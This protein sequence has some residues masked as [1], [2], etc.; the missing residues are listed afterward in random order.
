MNRKAYLLTIALLCTVAQGAWAEAVNYIYYT[1]NDDG[2]TVTKHTGSQANYNTINH[3]TRK[4][5]AGVLEIWWVVSSNVTIDTKERLDCY[6]KVNIILKDGCTLTVPKGIR[7]STDCT[8]NI[9]AQSEDEATMGGIHAEGGGEDWAAIGG[10]KDYVGGTLV[11]H[12]GNIY[13]EAKNNNAAGIGGGNGEKS[14]MMSITIYGGIV[15]AKGKN[16]GAGIGAGKRNNTVGTINIYGGTITAE[17]GDYGAGIGGA[18]DRGGWHTNIYGGTINTKG[19]MYAAGIGGGNKGDGGNVNI[20][21]GHVTSTGGNKGAGIGGGYR[22]AGG[23]LNIHGGYITAYGGDHGAAIGGGAVLYDLY[24]IIHSGGGG[25]NITIYDCEYLYAH[26]GEDAACIG[27]GYYGNSGTITIKGGNVIATFNRDNK[28]IHGDGAAIGGGG[29][30]IAETINIEGGTVQATNTRYEEGT[31][32]SQGAAIGAGGFRGD[33]F[34]KT[35]GTINISGGTITAESTGPG[36]VAG[37]IGGG[38]RTTDTKVNITGGRVTMKTKNIP[39]GAYNDAN[40]TKLMLGDNMSVEKSLDNYVNANQR[41]STCTMFEKTDDYRVIRILPCYHNART[42]TVSADSHT[43]YCKLCAMVFAAES[44][45]YETIGGTCTQCGFDSSENIVTIGTF[46]PDANNIYQGVGYPVVKGQTFILPDCDV[47]V[48]GMMFK[49]WLIGGGAPSGIETA[50]SEDLK[51]PGYEYTATD[52]VSIFARYEALHITLSNSDTEDNN[53]SAINLYNGLTA[54]DVTLSE[55]VLYKDG[56]WN[57]LTLPFNHTIDT[58]SPLS[59]ATVMYLNNATFESST[60]TLTLDFQTAAGGEMQAGR[61]YI[62]KW[63]K[64]EPYTPYDPANPS[65]ACSDIVNPVFNNVEISS[66]TSYSEFDCL[67]FAGNYG[68][69]SLEADNRS[70]LYLGAGNTLYYPNDAMTINAFRAFFTLNGITA[71]NP[72]SGVHAFVLNVGDGKATG[73][74]S[75]TKESGSERAV[76]GWYDLQGRRLSDKPTAKGLYI[77][78]GV[79]VIIK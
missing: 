68:T 32:F 49:G 5:D 17:G 20:Y 76:T 69:L 23:N 37:C 2:K 35:N 64:P 13:A 67:T 43:G 11:I 72:N 59:G 55:R 71:G 40:G 52:N 42:Y 19:G 45:N 24:G 62:V 4:L 70:I 50:A 21:G 38:L 30:G 15:T 10:H 60:G 1:V 33:Y 22:G 25:G 41:V 74:I 47:D 65:T 36:G 75:V 39:I 28:T 44:H 9:Y 46:K 31:Y 12:G 14:G 66:T 34:N 48:T 8:L 26:G 58:T 27:G 63:V 6:G 73:I 56:S 61:P 51:S 16:N 54:T 57:T 7:V 53:W 77:N 18:E 3:S 79:K 78:N 29:H